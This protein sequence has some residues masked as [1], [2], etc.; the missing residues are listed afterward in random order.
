MAIYEDKDGL[1][2]CWSSAFETGRGS[3]VVVRAPGGEE[4]RCHKAVL[5]VFSEH[6]QKMFESDML[7]GSKGCVDVKEVDPV[8]LHSMI[9]FMYT[10]RCTVTSLSVIPLMAVAERFDVQSLRNFCGRY[11]EQELQITRDNW[12]DLL[13]LCAAYRVPP[14]ATRLV[15]AF[16]DEMIVDL[17]DWVQI[18]PLELSAL[19]SGAEQNRGPLGF[20]L[21][22]AVDV[23][24]SHE[25]GR[26]EHGLGILHSFDYTKFTTQ[27][28]C[29]LRTLDNVHACVSLGPQ[30]VASMAKI[31]DKA[32]EHKQAASRTWSQGDSGSW[33]APSSG[34]FY[35]L[36]RGQ[37]GSSHNGHSGGEGAVVGGACLLKE[38]DELLIS[39]GGPI[40]REESLHRSS[41]VPSGGD[42]SYIASVVKGVPAKSHSTL[43]VAGGGGSS[44]WINDGGDAILEGPATG[45]GKKRQCSTAGMSYNDVY[46]WPGRPLKGGTDP[47]GQ[48]AGGAG[49]NG[50]RTKNYNL[51][52]SGG[53][54][55]FICMGAKNVVKA[56]NP[57]DSCEVQI[58]SGDVLPDNFVL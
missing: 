42:A 50:G 27:E 36:A 37:R 48:G 1:V 47:E 29:E 25:D 18:S 23:W 20:A 52:C 58:F 35:L 51:P 11:V 19:M 6:F 15:D 24:T 9:E 2:A 4:I 33:T 38:G 21:A 41:S 16:L 12:S 13:K 39:A 49:Y 10:G 31:A 14:L 22:K 40:G 55:C 28:I 46:A 8:A 26:Q 34:W 17:A 57:M 53:G 44:S 7:E 5:S 3:D 56:Y 32:R 30:I 45:T 54:S 43:F